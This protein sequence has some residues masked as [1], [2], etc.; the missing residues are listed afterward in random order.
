MPR[1][2]DRK[3]KWQPEIELPSSKNYS[4]TLTLHEYLRQFIYLI[5]LWDKNLAVAEM[6]DR[7]ATIDMDRK[8][9]GAMPF[10]W[11]SWAPSNTVWPGPRSTFVP[12]GIW[13]HPA[14]WP[15]QTWTE[16]WGLFPFVDEGELGPHLKQCGRGRGLPPC[17]VYSW[18]I[19]LFGHST[20]TLQ[21]GQDRQRSDSVGRTVLQT[22]AR[23]H[24]NM[25]PTK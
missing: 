20:P 11:E 6:G 2:H 4:S 8:E 12:S 10:P 18:V 16:N 25:F 21:T 15:Q 13:V 3:W 14:V 22:V 17:Q 23:K 24:R 9:E 5:P 7:L 19:E 1:K